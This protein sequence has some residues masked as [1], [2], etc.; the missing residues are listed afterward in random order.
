METGRQSARPAHEIADAQAG[1]A[2]SLTDLAQGIGVDDEDLTAAIGGNDRAIAERE[3]LP[4]FDGHH[5]PALELIDECVHCGFCL[6][7]CPTYLLWGEEMDSPRGRI[8]LMREGLEG[9][10]MNDTMVR[11]FDQCLG[12]LAC[13]SACPS[14]VEYGKLIE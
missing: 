12:C 13:V 11:H 2:P 1:G 10:A 3:R 7:T 9:E 5:A 6:P 4:A 8:Y 14:G